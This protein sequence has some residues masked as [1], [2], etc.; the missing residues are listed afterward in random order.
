MR[1]YFLLGAVALMIS[2]TANASNQATFNVYSEVNVVS[3]VECIS[4]LNFGKIQI[5]DNGENTNGEASVTITYD[6]HYTASE[7]V[8]AITGDITSAKCPPSTGYWVLPTEPIQLSNDVTL[9][10]ATCSI[11]QF[12]ICGTINIPEGIASSTSPKS[13]FGTVT[14]TT[15]G[16]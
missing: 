3:E 5:K 7:N 1:K 2:S 9:T 16:N 15:F 8:V 13:I 14:V 12:E 11:S 4:D 10:L 6:N